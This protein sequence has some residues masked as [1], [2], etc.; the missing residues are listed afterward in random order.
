V[1]GVWGLGGAVT[2]AA[3]SFRRE[4]PEASA[5]VAAAPTVPPASAAPESGTGMSASP[6]TAAASGSPPAPAPPVGAPTNLPEALTQRRANFW[7]RMGAGFLDWV[8]VGVVG[9]LVHGPPF[10][11][12][13]ALAYFAGMWAWKGTTVGGIVLGTK[14]VRLDGQPVTFMVAL[15]RA[16]ACLLSLFVFFLGFLWII[17]DREKQGWHDKIA[18]TVV[19]RVAKSMPLVCL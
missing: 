15:V 2:A 18:G 1:V 4:S 9:A 11:F 8:I 13:V 14:V 12:L 6:P 3:G 17:W 19:V 7:E 10:G 5:A 16:L